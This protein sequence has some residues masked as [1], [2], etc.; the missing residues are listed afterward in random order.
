MLVASHSKY[1][2]VY[3]HFTFLLSLQTSHKEQN[4]EN[5]NIAAL[6]FSLTRYTWL[7]VSFYISTTK[8]AFITCVQFFA[9]HFWFKGKQ[10]I[11][12][13]IIKK[14]QEQG[15]AEHHLKKS[16]S[17]C[18]AFSYNILF[19]NKIIL[20]GFC[21]CIAR[22]KK[23]LILFNSVCRSSA[24]SWWTTREKFFSEYIVLL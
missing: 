22:Y 13:H 7:C 11:F 5:T 6:I 18:K 9:C 23:T 16:L 4:V 2:V 21:K 20:V 3:R 14:R 1:I 12:C 19:F 24:I 10:N 15:R 8:S 17:G